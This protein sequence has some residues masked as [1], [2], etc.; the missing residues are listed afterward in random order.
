MTNEEIKAEEY[1]LYSWALGYAEDLQLSLNTVLM[2]IDALAQIGNYN[3]QLVKSALITTQDNY[4]NIDISPIPKTKLLWQLGYDV[5]A[6]AK[7]IGIDT[8]TVKKHIKNE[9]NP[10]TATYFVPYITEAQVVAIRQFFKTMYY[11][12]GV[13]K[14][15]RRIERDPVAR[16]RIFTGISLR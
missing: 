15:D 7:T 9:D 5:S 2:F 13:T 10:L 1:R 14:Y 3:P 11:I 4:R 8:R 16:T 6:I 12:G